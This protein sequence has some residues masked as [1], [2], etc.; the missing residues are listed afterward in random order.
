VLNWIFAE[1][2]KFYP[3]SQIKRRSELSSGEIYGVV[4]GKLDYEWSVHWWIVKQLCL[5]GWEP[6]AVGKEAHRYHLRLEVTDNGED[7]KGGIT[8]IESG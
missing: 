4:I 1:V 6:F 5:Q 8:D 2:Q 7:N 3:Y